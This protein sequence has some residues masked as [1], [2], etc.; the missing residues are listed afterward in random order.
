[1]NHHDYRTKLIRLWKEPEEKNVK[2]FFFSW[3]QSIPQKD[4]DIS[5]FSWNTCKTSIGD[6]DP[7]C[8]VI[9]AKALNYFS[10]IFKKYI[11]DR[12]EIICNLLAI[13]K[14]ST[15]TNSNHERWRI[16]CD[17]YYLNL[18]LI[19]DCLHLNYCI[20]KKVALKVEGCS[21][22]SFNAGLRWFST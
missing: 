16:F 14:S 11:Q 18:L 5:S 10:I 15:W 1:M 6:N 3:N 21:H 12:N 13:L 19:G 22:V 8:W 20:S 17:T 9:I 2:S 7:I 4:D